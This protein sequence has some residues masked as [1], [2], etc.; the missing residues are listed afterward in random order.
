[1]DRP[2]AVW[3]A[4]S[5]TFTTLWQ[6]YAGV[7]FSDSVYSGALLWL[8]TML[9]PRSGL[10]GGA[11]VISAALAARAFGLVAELAHASAYTYSALFIGLGAVHTFDSL[12]AVVALAVLGA[13]ISPIL[14]ASAFTALRSSGVPPL[15]LPF[16]LVYSCAW[17]IGRVYGAPWASPSP[18]PVSPGAELAAPARLLLEGLGGLFFAPRTD[19]GALVLVA[20][21]LSSRHAPGLLLIS[22]ATTLLAAWIFP[23]SHRVC[24]GILANACLT[25][26]G[27]GTFW[28]A[29][30]RRGYAFAL[31]GACACV[32]ITLGLAGPLGLL[33]FA[34]LSL[35]FTL[36]VSVLL[37]VE[38][39]RAFRAAVPATQV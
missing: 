12:A 20:M 16:W 19:V 8:A 10:L 34:P 23:L 2:L 5:R 36:S 32:A 25:A 39:A 35:P 17:S 30:S 33:G 31:A 11:A 38:R 22:L 28:N 13:L 37:V 6:L 21:C 3:H 1:M 29:P 18:Q 24:L 26:L 27:M 14:T 7:I 9:E 15:S 4:V